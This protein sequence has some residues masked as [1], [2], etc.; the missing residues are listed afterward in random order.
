MTLQRYYVFFVVEVAR[1][2]VHILAVTTNPD[3]AWTTQQIRNLLMDLG[4]RVDQFTVL[5]RGSGR[6]VHRRVRRGPHRRRDHGRQD[7]ATLSPRQR[8]R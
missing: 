2:C 7:P 8:L 1:R 4:E 6:A 3:G 5:I